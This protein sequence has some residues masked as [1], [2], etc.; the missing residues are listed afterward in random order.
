MFLL[1]VA[2]SFCK[3]RR[4]SSGSTTKNRIPSLKPAAKAG[5]Q[6]Y[7]G[8]LLTM[9]TNHLLTALTNWDDPPSLPIYPP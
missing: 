8:D 7:L 2:P 5:K 3:K 4:Q 9:V 6:P 1:D